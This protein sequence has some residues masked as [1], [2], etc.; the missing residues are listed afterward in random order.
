MTYLIDDHQG[1]VFLTTDDPLVTYPHNLK[2][3]WL[4]IRMPINGPFER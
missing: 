1:N 2:E 3:G 4:C